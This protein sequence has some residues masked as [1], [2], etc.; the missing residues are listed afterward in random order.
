MHANAGWLRDKATHS[1]QGTWGLGPEI[2]LNPRRTLVAES[3][4]SDSSNAWWQTGARYDRNPG[5]WQLGSTIGRQLGG[6]SDTPSISFG[7]RFTP[8]ALF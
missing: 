7:L 6:T 2:N 3:F 5:L 8:D 4:G 1:Q